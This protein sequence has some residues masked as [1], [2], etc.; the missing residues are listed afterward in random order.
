MFTLCEIQLPAFLHPDRPLVGVELHLWNY[1]TP[2][3]R[4]LLKPQSHLQHHAHQRRST[5]FAKK[6]GGFFG[7]DD[8]LTASLSS[9]HIALPAHNAINCHNTNELCSPSLY[10]ANAD[11]AAYK[12]RAYRVEYTLWLRLQCDI[13]SHYDRF[14]SVFMC[15]FRS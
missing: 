9:S 5:V 7:N 10:Y 13:F 15:M 6:I 3:P 11:H 4:S 8:V 14:C 12:L 2:E 1:C